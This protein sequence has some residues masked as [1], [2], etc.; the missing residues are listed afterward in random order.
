M[1]SN[2]PYVRAKDSRVGLYFQKSSDQFALL[3]KVGHLHKIE[4]TNFEK[5]LTFTKKVPQAF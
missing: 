5:V 2:W 4:C 3:P 1:D